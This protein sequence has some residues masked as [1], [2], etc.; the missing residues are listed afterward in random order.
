MSLLIVEPGLHT[1]LVDFGRP[2]CRS[3]GVPVGGAAD[4]TA[5]SLGNALVGNSPGAAGL[6]ITLAGPTVQAQ[7]DL[8]CVIFGAPFSLKSDRQEL[9][10]DI[11][12]TLAAGETLR[13]GAAPHGARA[14]LCVQGGF[15]APVLLGSRSG[16]Y[17]LAAGTTISCPPGRIPARF[18][19]SHWQR[20]SSGH[21]SHVLR[22]TSGPQADWFDRASF[23]G[24]RFAVTS[25][26]NRVGV[27]LDGERLVRSRE[28]ELLS[29]PVC[30]G[31]IQILHDGRPVILGVDGQTI[32]GYPKVAQV[33]T[34]DMDQM[35]QLRPDDRVQF[36]HVDL[37]EAERLY[38]Q[39]AADLANWV[40][41]LQTALPR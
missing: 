39:K 25:A 38:R 8:A 32:G 24:Q 2:G 13:V 23:Y 30:P 5:L 10:P 37:A 41:R 34:A 35:G 14:Y 9:R 11:T 31:T 19:G 1:L 22:A 27:R 36:V 7:C 4:R 3:L 21:P 29:E 6:E 26:A 40:L 16:L 12:F 17:P 33:I 15:D 20:V 28:E 18:L